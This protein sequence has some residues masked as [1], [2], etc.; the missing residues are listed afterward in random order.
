MSN[1]ALRRDFE[2]NT[3][4]PL[5]TV[6]ALMRWDPFA[7]AWP[8]SSSG[9][10]VAFAPAFEVK[11]TK[12]AFVIKADMPGVAE[13]ELDIKLTEDR[14]VV[15]GK[16]QA[17][18]VSETDTYHTYERAFGSF[19]RSFVLPDTINSDAVR[20]ELKDGVLTLTLPK[21]PER[22]PKKVEISK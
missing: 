4:D 20:A 18:K 11:E 1:V 6:R 15:S 22:Q 9:R 13:A 17:E 2:R 5:Q 8:S 21:R 3:Q 16:R 7:E 10:E 14:L 19:T 12:E